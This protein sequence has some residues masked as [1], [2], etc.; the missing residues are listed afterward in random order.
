MLPHSLTSDGIQRVIF[1][2]HTETVK[3]FE[4]CKRW[5]WTPCQNVMRSGGCVYVCVCARGW[6][7]LIVHLNLLARW[8]AQ[9]ACLCYSSRLQRHSSYSGYNQIW[10]IYIHRANSSHYCLLQKVVT[11]CLLHSPSSGVFF[12]SLYYV[13]GLLFLKTNPGTHVICKTFVTISFLASKLF[14]CHV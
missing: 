5:G 4:G 10:G 6:H 14:I 8:P 13:L 3:C 1:P 7:C 9:Y 12:Q 2:K 11:A